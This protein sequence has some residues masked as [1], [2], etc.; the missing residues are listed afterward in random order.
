MGECNNINE[1]EIHGDETYERHNCDSNADCSDTTGGFTCTCR[2][3]YN[4]SGVRC[5]GK[6]LLHSRMDSGVSETLFI[7]N[8]GE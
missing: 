7:I 6:I 8:F 5:R 1:C 2:T 4:G 3:G